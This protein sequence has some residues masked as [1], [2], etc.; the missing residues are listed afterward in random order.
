MVDYNRYLDAAL[1]ERTPRQPDEFTVD[2]VAKR[3][4]SEGS[5]Q[6]WIYA[7]V[8]SGELT[9]RKVGKF[10]LYKPA[11]PGNGQGTKKAK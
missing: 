2:D 9:R 8:S 7:R 3:L 11:E 5:A 1:A 4:G 10:Y 6:R